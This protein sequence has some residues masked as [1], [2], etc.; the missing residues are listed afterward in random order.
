MTPIVSM[1]SQPLEFTL[2]HNICHISYYVSIGKH[3]V[4]VIMYVFVSV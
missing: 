1:K 4:S 2:E 3:V